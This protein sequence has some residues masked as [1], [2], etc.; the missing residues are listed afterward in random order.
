MVCL[1]CSWE[2]GGSS[3]LPC[4]VQCVSLGE[5]AQARCNVNPKSD[6]LVLHLLTSRRRFQ[7]N[8]DTAVGTYPTH[9]F[10]IWRAAWKLQICFFFYFNM[11]PCFTLT[12]FV[13]VRRTLNNPW[14][15]S[16]F[17]LNIANHHIG[18][19]INRV[20]LLWLTDDPAKPQMATLL[21]V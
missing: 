21:I 20:L 4:N 2:G 12:L 1:T 6:E 13:C 15:P 18:C 19:L 7:A 17:P 10:S 11:R 8:N 16:F 5:F 3:C 9:Q 14:L